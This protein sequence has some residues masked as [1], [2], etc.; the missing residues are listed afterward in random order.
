[1]SLLV[2]DI[3]IIQLLFLPF[4]F[5]LVTTFFGV[6]IFKRKILLNWK[7]LISSDSIAVYSYNSIF[8]IFLPIFFLFL[9]LISTIRTTE[10]YF[11]LSQL[12]LTPYHVKYFNLVFNSFM[13]SLFFFRLSL[14]KTTLN[15]INEIF[16]LSCWL[17]WIFF[18]ITL[19]N[20]LLIY[21]FFLEILSILLIVLLLY[22]YLIANYTGGVSATGLKLFNLQYTTKFL[23]FQ[24]ILFFLWSSSISML[25]LFWSCVYLLHICFTLDFSILNLL[26]SFDTF[27][28]SYNQTLSYYNFYF[29]YFTFFVSILLKTAIVPMHMW[30]ITFY[31]N[32][33]LLSIFFYLLLYYIYF[34]IIVFNLLFNYLLIFSIIWKFSFLILLILNFFIFIFN[35]NETYT[36]RS[37]IAVSSVLNLFLLFLFFLI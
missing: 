12:C 22:S 17:L 30:L 21:I 13:L 23:F 26:F 15:F 4:Y 2:F 29:V 32:L 27:Y 18:W 7:I 31:K 33:P 20:N 24:A 1:M 5:L 37:F 34:I 9:L 6:H 3:T 19:V 36:F 14:L 16:F 8:V 10:I 11:C 28:L 25:L 35:I